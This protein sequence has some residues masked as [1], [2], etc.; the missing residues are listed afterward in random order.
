[1]ALGSHNRRSS[2]PK[3]NKVSMIKLEVLNT[4]MKG[5]FIKIFDGM[6][7]GSDETCKVRAKL[8]SIEP[9]HAIFSVDDNMNITVEAGSKAAHLYHNNHDVMRAELKHGDR[10]YV[11]PLKFR[12]VNETLVSHMELKIDELLSTVDEND[13]GEILDFATEDLFYLC[14]K[15]PDLRRSI[16]FVIPSTDRYIDQAQA[17]LSRLAHQADVDEMKIEAFMT[18]TKELV[19]NAHRHGHEFDESKKIIIRYRDLGDALQLSIE[20]EGKGFDHSQI[21]GGVDGKNAAD[22]ARERYKAGGFGGL[23]FQMITRMS[24]ELKYNDKGNIV[25]FKVTKHFP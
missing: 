25:T 15:D 19:L 5:K 23:G 13:D 7:V 4:K 20:D 22:A 17:F 11:G 8:D 3:G 6:R 16:N 12:V 18:C 1:M 21:V 24:S 14:K 9:V 10:I 2:T